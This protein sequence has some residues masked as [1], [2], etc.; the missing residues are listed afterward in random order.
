MQAQYTRKAIAKLNGKTFGSKLLKIKFEQPGR[1]GKS[2]R[3][4]QY[5]T[6]SCN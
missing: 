5:K 4:R 1:G 2:P 6:D 3:S